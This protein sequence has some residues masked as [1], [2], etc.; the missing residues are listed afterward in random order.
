MTKLRASDASFMRSVYP[1]LIVACG[2]LF[3]CYNYFLRVSPG[4]MQDQLTQAFHIKAT[5]FGALAGLYYWA[6]TPMQM[7]AGLIYDKFGVR[8]VLSSALFT[9]VLGL[10]V[11][12]KADNFMLAAV[13]RFLIGAGCAFAYIGTLKLAA[14]WLPPSRFAFVAGLTTAAGMASGA[15]AQRYL[16]DAVKTVDYHSA[17]ST[18][19]YV[20]LA[21]CVFVVLFVRSHPKNP[22]HAYIDKPEAINFSQLLNALKQVFSNRQM[23]LIGIIGGLVYLPSSVFLDAW[24]VPY[25][26]TV[27]GLSKTE[28]VSMLGNTFY[29]WIVAGPLIGFISDK[30]RLRK[31]PLA[32]CGFFAALILCMIFYGPKYEISTLNLMFF[33]IGFFCGSHSICFALGKES[34]PIEISGTAVAVTNMLIMAGG[35]IFQ[36]L[37]GKLLDLHTSSLIGPNGLPQYSSADYSF[38]L[39][40]IPLGVALGIFLCIF[41]K[42]THGE[43]RDVEADLALGGDDGELEPAK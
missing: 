2:M 26:K 27:Y 15:M 11:F 37:A 23:W 16:T 4:V 42:E 3:Y 13:G 25:L 40:L 41:L 35:M 18:V 10:A 34:N 38:A 9:S 21:L 29:G 7:P 31:L 5:A 24:G 43:Y 33:L 30:I 32:I 14:I 20:G 36:P 1:W 6:Y 39:S 8:F 12:V 22:D 28:A 17:L 19:L